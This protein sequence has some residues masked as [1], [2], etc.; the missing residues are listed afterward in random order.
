MLLLQLHKKRFLFNLSSDA[1]Y[2]T[3]PLLDSPYCIHIIQTVF[4]LNTPDA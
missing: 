2:T 1:E 4:I 3:M